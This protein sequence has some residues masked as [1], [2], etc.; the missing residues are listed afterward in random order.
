MPLEW[1]NYEDRFPNSPSTYEVSSELLWPLRRM[2]D[3]ECLSFKQRIEPWKR[4]PQGNTKDVSVRDWLLLLLV[5]PL[6]GFLSGF[7]FLRLPK[8]RGEISSSVT[9]GFVSSLRRSVAE[10]ITAFGTLENFRS[11]FQVSKLLIIPASFQ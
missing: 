11:L 5:K 1:I 10:T 7:C 3:R 8:N 6:S 4:R 2:W 9:R